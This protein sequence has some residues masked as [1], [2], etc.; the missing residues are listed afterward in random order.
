M[1]LKKAILTASTL[2][3]CSLLNPLMAQEG[4]RKPPAAILKTLNADLPA[5]S[6]LSPRTDK[7]LLGTMIRYP[8][9]KELSVPF[10]RL[11]G[12]RVT[13]HNKSLH[14]S[15]YLLSSLVL[16]DVASGQQKT[17]KVPA[18]SHLSTPQWSA[19]GKYF[20]FTND[21]DTGVEL[22]VGEADTGAVRRLDKVQ[23][24]RVL[25]RSVTWMPD[26]QHLL[27]KLIDTKAGKEPADA[28]VFGPSIQESLGK[29]KAS[30]T[31]EV[32]DVLKNPKDEKLFE[33][34]GRSQLALIDV[35][36][37][38]IKKL[39]KPDLYTKVEP[40]P[41]GQNILVQSI[42]RPFSYVTTYNRFPT[43][44]AVWK[45]NGQGTTPIASLP[46]VER[47][48]IHGVQ[49]GPRDFQ[50]RSNEP[51]T[52][53]YV[54]ALDGGESL[55][56]A[57][58]RDRVMVL[59]APF[60]GTAQEVY[61]ADQRLLSLSWGEQKDLTLATESDEINH[62]IKISRI[63]VDGTQAQPQVLE[64]FSE[65]DSYGKPGNYVYR[66]QSNGQKLIQQNG[67]RVYLNG[68]GGS[69]DGDR[70]FLD[71]M[72][73]K[74][75]KKERLFR[76]DRQHLETFIGWVGSN[77]KD[78]LTRRE[79]SKEFPNYFVRSLTQPE[80]EAVTGEA[81]WASSSKTL[82]QF[83]NPLPELQGIT[84]Q[85]VKYKRADGVDLSFTL[86]LP[87]GYQKGT[88]LPTVMWA[89][90]LDY[91]DAK[92][93]GQV[94]GSPQEYTMWGFD[95]HLFFLL[96]GYAVI[97]DAS[98]P[99][100]GDTNRIY[101]TYLEQLVAGAEAAVNKAVELGVTDRNRIGVIGHSHGGLMTVN[102]LAH[103]DLFR[104]GI[105]RSGAYNRSLTA[106]GF[107]SEARTVWEAP[108]VYRKVSP[109]FVADKIKKPLLLV[110]G[111]A[112]A[113]P[114]TETLQSEKMYEAVRGNGGTVRLV[115][116]PFES[117]GYAARESIEHVVWESLQ[118]FDTYVKNA[119][120]RD[121]RQV[122]KT[123]PDNKG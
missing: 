86:Y 76:S 95:V 46:L 5:R 3:A 103:T 105:A 117:H 14:G 92:V 36:T 65:D 63:D 116:L 10:Y 111:A 55:K 39:G 47:V 97:D 62:M 70:P 24:N 6:I 108:E 119:D 59:K 56:K 4:Y 31:Y 121:E 41:D 91:S 58:G 85:V 79:S 44:V 60:Q 113:N 16:V 120:K 20:A 29:A 21:T 54:E 82:T 73:L 7:L 30:S 53:V 32:R 69:P 19:D 84:K 80:G 11:A 9:I 35:K 87:P 83:P 64:S 22:W 37:G 61:K 75:L 12:V 15:R 100:I 48:P 28:E 115:R 90:P 74:T 102:L 71:A 89:Y 17:L 78:F 42:H 51:A 33:Y 110:H 23:V 122:S 2:I 107:Q 112:D 25:D 72:N 8:T 68:L 18:Q 40:A 77:G 52:L 1:S 99:V 45:T 66:L 67:D 50:W 109:F 98:I 96:A 57:E 101:D 88:R 114:G 106:F 49:T 26:Q 27:V 118:W 94:A 34:Y 93:A 104:A 123:V 43:E 38:Q 81:Q 13:P